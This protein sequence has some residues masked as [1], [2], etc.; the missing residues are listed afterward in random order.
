MDLNFP[1]TAYFT[2]HYLNSVLKQTFARRRAEDLLVPFACPSTDIVHFESKMHEEGP[3]WR[4]VR[5]SMSLVGFVPPL[6]YQER[7]AHDG[8]ISQSLLV[9]GGYVNQ[10]PVEVLR[11]HGA[12]IVICV[13]AAPDY[14]PVNTDYGDIVKGG[15]VLLRR[16]IETWFGFG[17]RHRGKPDPPSQ[18][19][20]QERLM[21]LVD[22]MKES[23]DL[24]ADISIHPKTESYALLDF[25]KYEEI[26]EI[27]YSA[28][29][30]RFREWLDGGSA[31]AQHVQAVIKSAKVDQP[32]ANLLGS[33]NPQMEYGTRHHYGNWRR[34][35]RARTREFSTKL[36]DNLLGTRGRSNSSTS[37]PELQAEQAS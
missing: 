13:V 11:E 21:F 34:R 5:A 24:R 27:G 17:C 37:L 2:G 30:P 16:F 28:A 33:A 18:A 29:M 35:F 32:S 22:S 10:H 9:D 4:I 19:E 1:R 6:P 7:R 25:A 14:G 12:G 8:K 3:L 36:T 26:K 23:H 31:A 20:I 15:L